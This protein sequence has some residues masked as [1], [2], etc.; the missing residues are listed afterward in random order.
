MP[1]ETEEKTEEKQPEEKKPAQPSSPVL[2][3]NIPEKIAAPKKKGGWFQKIPK[4]IFLSPGGV[5]LIF[6]ALLIEVIDWIP[7]PVLDQIIELPLEIIFMVFLAV[8]A[9]VSF[10]GMI[11]PFVIERIP[12]INDI[13]PTWLIKILM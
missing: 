11:I 6:L 5:I 7:L 1:E 9:K 12:I 4:D 13:L 10:K 3:E 8:I 2:T